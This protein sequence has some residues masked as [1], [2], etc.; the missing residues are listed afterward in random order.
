L[1]ILKTDSVTFTPPGRDELLNLAQ[2]GYT[3]PR[4]SD[5]YDKSVDWIRRQAAQWPEVMAIIVANGKK[6][7]AHQRPFANGGKKI[8]K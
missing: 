8:V 5:R 2:S 4:L 1:A 6:R 3:F 7:H